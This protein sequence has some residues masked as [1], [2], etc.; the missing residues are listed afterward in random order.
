[1]LPPA[2]PSPENPTGAK[3]PPGARPPDS[4]TPL[5]TVTC[6]REFS[7]AH[8]LA[9]PSLDEAE[10]RRLYGPCADL[11]GHNYRLEVSIRGPIDP[12]TGMVVNFSEVFEAISREILV[13]CDHKNLNAD[14]PFLAGIITTAE[15]LAERF[16]S[17][18]E[19]HVAALPGCQLTRIRL[20]ETSDT[21][22]DYR[23]PS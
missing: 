20:H 15:N 22:V 10:N 14:V 21:T 18:L 3:A 7:A 16:W 4:K 11:H 8:V 5:A 12:A 17:I 1:M 13:P 2:M 6:R 9:S 23:G 19:P